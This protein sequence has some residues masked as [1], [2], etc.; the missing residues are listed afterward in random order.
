MFCFYVAKCAGITLTKESRWVSVE[1]QYETC[2]MI[3]HLG[4]IIEKNF[5]G[6]DRAPQSCKFLPNQRPIV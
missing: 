5:S 3:D 2:R 4:F 1:F 6:E